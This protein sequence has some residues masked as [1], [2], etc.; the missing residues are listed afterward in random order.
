MTDEPI[1]WYV[2][3]RVDLPLRVATAAFDQLVVSSSRPGPVRLAR[4][5]TVDPTTA[6]PGIERRLR[7][8]LSPSGLGGPV[9]IELELVP[10]SDRCVELGLRPARRP[11]RAR[12]GRYFDAV[13]GALEELT[14]ALYAG[15]A[16]RIV[17]PAA[18]RRAS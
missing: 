3:R 4:P 9:P 12:A 1:T 13:A 11:P 15:S 5:L 7:G 18:V 17:P 14:D 16:E 6:R 10:W 8:R 2:S